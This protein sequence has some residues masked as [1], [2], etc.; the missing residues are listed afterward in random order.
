VNVDSEAAI[1]LVTITLQ[2]SDTQQASLPRAIDIIPGP[3]R[4]QSILP[5]AAKQGEQIVELLIQGK[6][7][8]RGI[9]AS[10]E[11]G[12]RTLLL[13]AD[14]GS[15]LSAQSLRF[16]D[17]F[18]AEDSPLG[19]F[20]VRLTNP[21]GQSSRLSRAFTITIG[22]PRV[23]LR[24]PIHLIKG[25]SAQNLLIAGR[26]FRPGLQLTFDRPGLAYQGMP[27]PEVINFNQ[28][29]LPGLSVSAETKPGIVRA[30]L[31]IPADTPSSQ[32][33]IILLTEAGPLITAIKPSQI[34]R[35]E[36]TQ[37]ITLEGDHF[38]AGSSMQFDDASLSLETLEYQD[39]HRIVLRGFKAGPTARLGEQFFDLLAPDNQ[40]TRGALQVDGGMIDEIEPARVSRG[41]ILP[42]LKISGR[43]FLAGI[44]GE[45]VGRGIS[46]GDT[47]VISAS[48]LELRQIEVAPD[49]AIGPRQVRLLTPRG[50]I[51]EAAT[52]LEIVAAST[53]GCQACGLM[54]PGTFLTAIPGLIL[55]LLGLFFWSRRPRS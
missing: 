42:V 32:A 39:A 16:R 49:V 19:L 48:R 40:A 33:D 22:D 12:S 55:H 8:K 31:S 45:I 5:Q 43:N 6:N 36:T 37:D 47:R 51:L 44:K 46:I 41:E 30:I 20:D 54:P 26:N 13:A 23:E 18:I 27:T 52:P 3:P 14:S 17:I 24:E 11:M 38:Q 9:Q 1:G 53:G 10:I 15:F 28:L 2:N 7:F 50:E 35:G 25:D 4:I 34:L 21:D 29:R